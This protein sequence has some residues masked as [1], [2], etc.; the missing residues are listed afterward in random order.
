MADN[1]TTPNSGTHWTDED[2]EIVLSQA[3]LP[4]NCER[5]GRVLGRSSKAVRW[6]FQIGLC[7]RR[8][9]VESDQWENAFVRQVAEVSHKMGIIK[10]DPG[11]RTYLKQTA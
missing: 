10:A 2:I 11:N 8:K 9:L 5:M 4:S 1:W 6:V 3:P 7:P